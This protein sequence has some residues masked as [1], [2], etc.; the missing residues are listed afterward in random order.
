MLKF[1]RPLKN[2]TLAELQP[3]LDQLATGQSF[4][5]GTQLFQAASCAA[6]HSVQEG[7]PRF[8]P[9][10]TKLDPKRKPLDVLR[11]M[12]EPSKEIEEKYQMGKFLL[13]SGKVVVG[14]VTEETDDE[15]TLMTDPLANC[16]PTILAKDEIEERLKSDISL[17]PAG[18]L[19]RFTE[20]EIL[21]L[22]A[23]VI[24]RGDKDAPVYRG[25]GSN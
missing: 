13:D 14:L 1:N 22:C 10:L 9:D 16:E 21:E 18:L 25:E 12:V 23:F 17:M 8:A 20:E 6:C 2:W 24:S 5:R 4:Q 3:A 15:V 7:Q 11:S 19:D